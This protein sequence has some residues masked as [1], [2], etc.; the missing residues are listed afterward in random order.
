MAGY[1]DFAPVYGL[2]SPDE[3]YDRIADYV[4][5]LTER[6]ALV[7][8]D[9]HEKLTVFD[10]ACGTGKLCERLCE[11]GFD[12]IGADISELCLNEAVMS[13]ADK[14]LPI[15][16]IMQD[17]R[18]PELYEA[19]DIVT[20]TFD[21]LDHLESA[22]DIRTAV[23][24]L[25]G[26]VRRGG[27]FVFDMNTPYKHREILGN[28]IFVYDTEE[29]YLVWSNEFDESSDENRVDMCLD[30]FLP[31]ADGRYRREYDEISEIA[32]PVGVIRE[33]AEK[34][35][36]KL[37]EMYGGYSCEPFDEVSERVV[38]AMEKR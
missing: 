30:M 26:C 25:S 29:V 15:R 3:E 32:L 2:L 24:G 31:D 28:N 10:A 20:C 5:A 14:G 1:S 22:E 17:L 11:R 19:A 8:S 38:F 21:S 16:Y 33:Y 6:Y 12:V 36:L 7:P 35:G 34:A 4:C 9:G 37:L 23:C 27:L 13:A 18:S